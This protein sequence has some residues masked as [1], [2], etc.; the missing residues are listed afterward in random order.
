MPH[1][2][3]RSRRASGAGVR[4]AAVL[5]LGLLA[6]CGTGSG[7]RAGDPS[8]LP[9][10]ERLEGGRASTGADG[11][12]MRVVAP[13]LDYGLAYPKR[14]LEQR[15]SF[16]AAIDASL[17]SGDPGVVADVNALK[18]LYEESSDLA[19]F[20]E[21]L[22]ERF[23]LVAV[24]DARGRSSL[25][26]LAT[27][28]ATPL[29]IVREKPDE[30]F[31]FPIL[32]DVR[33]AAPAI[34]D[35]SRAEILGSEA[36]RATAIAWIDDPLSWA[37]IETNGS[38]RLLVDG[39]SGKRDILVSRIGT[40]DRP[41]KGL[42]RFFAEQGL[43]DAERA[44]LDDVIRI[45]RERPDLAEQAALANDRVV[46]FARVPASEFVPT[47]GLGGGRLVGGYSCAADQAIHPPGTILVVVPR[48][49][50]AQETEPR[51]ARLLFVHDVGGAIEGPGRVDA[52]FGV[53]T[54]AL[55]RAGM[56]RAASD[57]YVLRRRG[58]TG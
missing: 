11:V 10:S 30:R 2:I 22:E 33:R 34:A 52:Y 23:E 13:A 12:S 1:E 44:T 37:L 18:Q 9:P 47:F 28:Y 6:A 56:T 27:G 7:S 49:L 14:T 42:G 53:G 46:Y 32:G 36:A 48:D 3:L 55:L 21:G 25:D 29:A 41:W 4:V 40:N 45:A 57:V 15:V 38:A 43:I 8:L 16:L 54:E 35:A 5:G 20:V 58:R 39:T 24:T 19:S 51:A 26:G 17:T 50:S 31:R